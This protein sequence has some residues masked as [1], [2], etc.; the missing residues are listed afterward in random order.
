M[1]NIRLGVNYFASSYHSLK[2]TCSQD[3]R[4]SVE[5]VNFMATSAFVALNN[6][7]TLL[8]SKAVNLNKSISEKAKA[9]V[10]GMTSRKKTGNEL[11]AKF[12]LY[13]TEPGTIAS[14]S[15]FANYRL[16]S[17][18]YYDDKP[19]SEEITGKLQEIKSKGGELGAKA[20]KL[21]KRCENPKFTRAS[22]DGD[23][24]HVYNLATFEL[25][26]EF[27][28]DLCVLINS[29]HLEPIANEIAQTFKF[30]YYQAVVAEVLARSIAYNPHLDGETIPLPVKMPDGNYEIANF[31]VKLYYLGDELPSYVMECKN[32]KGEDLHNPWLVARG[33]DTSNPKTAVAQRNKTGCVE[34]VLADLVHQDGVAEGIIDDGVVF[35]GKFADGTKQD[36]LELFENR[37]FNLTGHS[38]G[39]C[40]VNQ[41]ATVLNKNVNQAFAFGAPGVS[42]R[43]GTWWN[44]AKFDNTK[45]VNIQTE[46]DLVPA[47]GKKLIGTH[48]AYTPLE[49]PANPN[50]SL[51]HIMM[52]LTKPFKLQHV[53]I[54][55]ETIQPGRI[56]TEKA[57]ARIGTIFS[58]LASAFNRL[59]EWSTSTRVTS[60]N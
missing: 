30:D 20:E 14:F 57:R 13:P 9:T 53:D 36:L 48:I 56:F 1:N 41:A 11:T 22:F 60:I 34:S 29:K 39:G 16:T 19:V 44:E 21:L 49:M 27:S 37:Q 10:S 42:E 15:K 59:P 52:C 24:L 26:K 8:N 55:K 6:K 58:K 25:V 28:K 50:A 33:T 18:S 45:L 17:E 23:D 38:L 31:T 32:D 51:M 12:P 43:I 2:T 3:L 7:A 47:S 46:G 35:G 40:I 54:E 4:K 5:I